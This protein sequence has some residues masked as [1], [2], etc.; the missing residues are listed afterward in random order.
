MK[1]K[2]FSVLVMAFIMIFTL[3]ACGDSETTNEPSNSDDVG[4][5]TPVEKEVDVEF[6]PND[7]TDWP[8]SVRIAAASLGGTAYIYAGGFGS[9]IE[10]QTGVNSSL[11]VSG[12]PQHAIQLMEAGDIELGMVS[13]APA[14]DAWHGLE[15]WTGGK[16][17]KEMRVIFPM[18]QTVFHLWALE[19]SGI[20]N[21]DDLDGERLGVGPVGGTPGTYLPK[22]L[23]MLE[24]DFTPVNASVSDLVSQQLDGMLPAV[25]FASGLPFPAVIEAE[26]QRDLNF[27]GFS[28]EQVT[29]ITEELPYFSPAVVPAGTYSTQKEDMETI[30]VWN[31][32]IA[33]KDLPDSYIYQAVDSVMNNNEGMMDAHN[34]AQE[35]LPEN[36]KHNSFVYMHPGAIRWFE[37]NGYELPDGVYPP[38]YPKTK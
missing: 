34:V 36:I 38:E 31:M 23:D 26:A 22:F 21:I 9:L 28:K 32:A 2:Y 37:D 10:Q 6:D 7:E 14:W 20:S 17:F 24:I 27:F 16:E 11:E 18:Y 33:D 15:D 13:M 19:K 4:D 25:G 5:A 30:A 29:K 8:S 3:V 1:F 12:G 35:S